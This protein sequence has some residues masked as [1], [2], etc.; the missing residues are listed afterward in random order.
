MEKIKIEM[1]Q[2]EAE[3][4][5][6]AH[7]AATGE[8]RDLAVSQGVLDQIATTWPDLRAKYSIGLPFNSHY[9]P[10]AHHSD[11][12]THDW[13]LLIE[14]WPE[15]PSA[16]NTRPLQTFYAAPE[17][18]G[19]NPYGYFCTALGR[20]TELVLLLPVT[21][22]PE[23]REAFH[24]QL[25]NAKLIYSMLNPETLRKACQIVISAW[26]A[27]VNDGRVY[28]DSIKVQWLLDD[29]RR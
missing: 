11:L 2:A 17:C 21:V 20:K 5:V 28:F 7:Q 18:H 14:S 26:H 8:S 6:H 23:V 29:K 10:A 15:P 4:I 24:Q 3:T 16:E 22:S 25:E 13:L 12:C 1:D 9:V 19:A 27:M